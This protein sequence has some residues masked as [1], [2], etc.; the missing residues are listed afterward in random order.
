MSALVA[1][2]WGAARIAASGTVLSVIGFSVLVSGGRA[3]ADQID[4]GPVAPSIEQ[5]HELF[6]RV[7]QAKDHRSHGGDGLGP[8]FNGHS[9]VVCHD[10]GGV[11]GS[12]AREANV[13]VVAATGPWT[14]NRIKFVHPGLAHMR[15]VVLH[16]SSVD[17]NYER[18]RKQRLNFA[19][20]VPDNVKFPDEPADDIIVQR[21]KPVPGD[22][23]PVRGSRVLNEATVPVALQIQQGLARQSQAL[24]AIRSGSILDQVNLTVQPQQT[25]AAGFR[26]RRAAP[27]ANAPEEP[28]A[29]EPE[30]TVNEPG[31]VVSERNT[32]S[33]FGLGLVDT[34]PDWVIEEAAR[35]NSQ[36][37]RHCRTRIPGRGKPRRPFR[38]AC[39]TS[40][41]CRFHADRLRR[42]DWPRTPRSPAGRQSAQANLSCARAGHE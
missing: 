18:W 24:D 38:L 39:P 32:T 34:I 41:S 30:P 1:L 8:V 25:S 5:G 11:G 20:F 31:L 29:A 10:Q 9:C 28:T 15:R 12:G 22:R 35:G 40:D 13:N 33:L 23:V 14:R 21:Q 37:S 6:K 3:T 19:N 42:R 17:G 7:W 4:G 26:S 16:L 2:R 27:A 36:D